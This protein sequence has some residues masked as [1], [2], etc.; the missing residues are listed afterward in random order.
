[1]PST[2]Q[3]SLLGLPREVRNLIYT[4]YFQTLVFDGA[5]SQ[6]GD[7]TGARDTRLALLYA[8][9]QIHEE[10]S[11]LVLR[12]VRIC[13][14]GAS[15]MLRVLMA[16]SPAQVRQLKYLRVDCTMLCLDLP[17]EP[18]SPPSS[19]SSSAPVA[20]D[21]DGDGE[22]NTAAD[23]APYGFHVGA[24]LGLFPGLALDRLDLTDGFNGGLSAYSA[25]HGPDLLASLLRAD[26]Y[27]EARIALWN[28]HNCFPGTF[29]DRGQES[30]RADAR[31]ELDAW[32][33]LLRTRFR[34]RPGACV[35]LY[36]DETADADAGYW[37]RHREAGFTLREGLEARDE[38]RRDVLGDG[39]GELS[40]WN[41]R[42]CRGAGPC[43]V[44]EAAEGEDEEV[45]E[46]VQS[47]PMDAAELRDVSRHLRRLCKEADWATIDRAQEASGMYIDGPYGEESLW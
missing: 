20:G 25:Y 5:E 28:L 32:A 42:I 26:G 18:S 21:G 33:A 30:F 46:C 1:M 2:T 14:I 44:R 40:H 45:L 3:C 7:E 13:C 23:P 8:C 27:R 15:D 12:H 38:A 47:H 37:A 10:A 22:A 6:A 39:D 11:P 35:E 29:A 34:P 4:A 31:A 41:L 43:E 24:L 16:L 36:F 9:R 17:P 19:S